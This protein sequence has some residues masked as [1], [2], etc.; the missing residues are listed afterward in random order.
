MKRLLPLLALL[1]VASCTQDPS[2]TATPKLTFSP[3]PRPT[4]APCPTVTIARFAWPAGVPADLPQPPAATFQTT[5]TTADGIRLVRF[6]TKSSLQQSV[7]FVLR[8]VQKA[9]YTLARGDA[10]PAEADAPFGKG[11]LRGVYKMFVRDQCTTEWLVA[12][13]H[14]RP[15]GGSPILP[16]ASRGPSSSPLPFG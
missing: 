15:N 1:L 7:L 3:V 11:D 9:G 6:T 4:V 13:A 14:T 10:E 16:T 2:S 5:T 12:V 8:E